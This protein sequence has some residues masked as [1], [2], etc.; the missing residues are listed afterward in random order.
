[1]GQ[2]HQKV[3]L[4]DWQ[5]C[6]LHVVHCLLHHST[7]LHEGVQHQPQGA[8]TVNVARREAAHVCTVWWLWAE[9]NRAGNS[10]PC[11]SEVQNIGIVQ[12]GLPF[13]CGSSYRV[14][15]LPAVHVYEE[16]VLL[17][18]SP[19]TVWQRLAAAGR[20]GMFGSVTQSA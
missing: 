18:L 9:V 3:T 14:R 17:A 5:Q 11:L 15:Q 1:M 10:P 2:V 16:G 12:P 7:H 8:L 4:S 19:V 20:P 13:G 6:C